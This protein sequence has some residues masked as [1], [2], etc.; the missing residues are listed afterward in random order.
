MLQQSLRRRLSI[1]R[2]GDPS[3]RA[4]PLADDPLFLNYS[5]L[6]LALY[7][8]CSSPTAFP[9]G[10][11]GAESDSHGPQHL[12]RGRCVLCS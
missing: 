9:V 8:A 10:S 1:H 7:A 6:K 12:H 2:F 4:R 11:H 5:I 3:P